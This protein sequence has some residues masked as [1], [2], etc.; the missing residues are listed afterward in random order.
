MPM[1]VASLA[2]AGIDFSDLDKIAVTRGPGSFTGVRV[3]L[4][5]ARGIGIASGKPVIGIDRFS[6]YH[7]LH[8]TAG[9]NLL[10]VINSKRVELFCR[11]FPAVGA[12][13]ESCMM[14][15]PEIDIF[16]SANPGTDVA[17]DAVMRD[18]EILSVTAKLAAEADVGNP[19]FQ[20]RPLYLR[21]PDVTFPS[22]KSR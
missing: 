16:L 2:Q 20:P 10:V 3:G 8:A 1:I 11:F 18:E 6:I 22:T 13:H 21:A 17:G 9:R 4:A 7:A 15:Q 12:P 19:D 14:T 5:A